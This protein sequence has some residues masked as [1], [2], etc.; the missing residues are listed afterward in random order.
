MPFILMLLGGAKRLIGAALSWLS[1]RSIA[2]LACI[3][4]AI[5][6][7]VQ[8][9]RLADARHDEAAWKRNAEAQAKG[10]RE[11]RAA[12]ENAQRLASEKNK[13]HVQR[14]E[15]EQERINREAQSTLADRLERIRSELR[16][17]A[18]RG[19]AGGSGLPQSS[20][21]PC[22]AADPAWMCLSPEERLRAAENEERHES[23]IDWIVRQGEVE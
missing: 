7:I 17:Q 3:A 23:L 4:L 8:T 13:A 9:M 2:E 12:Y 5:L 14:I 6:A 21:A 1:R 11:D 15:A 20:E 18:A 16:Q 19:S 22:R 10:R